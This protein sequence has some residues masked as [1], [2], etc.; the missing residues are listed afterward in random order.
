MLLVPEGEGQDLFLLFHP[1][2]SFPAQGRLEYTYW[3]EGGGWLTPSSLLLYT[4][5][6]AQQW[7]WLL[8]ASSRSVATWGLKV[9][10]S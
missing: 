9:V 3:K 1:Y 4:A 6:S 8:V 7:Q 10:R 2:P 5:W